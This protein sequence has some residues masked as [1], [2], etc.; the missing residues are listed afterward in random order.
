MK[1]VITSAAMLTAVV[2]APAL[3]Q[4][5]QAAAEPAHGQHDEMR[6]EPVTRAQM[7]QKVQSHFA[8]VDADNDGV[9]TKAEMQAM[10]GARHERM[11]KHAGMRREHTFERLDTNDDGSISRSEFDAAHAGMAG[12]NGKAG[13]KRMRMHG[14]IFEMADANNDGRVTLQEATAAAAEHFDRADA[15][16]D[17]VLTA[18]EMRAAHKAHMGKPAG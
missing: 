11:E 18:D 6:M 1:L 8:R 4:T 9:V 10:R 3:A 13:H 7:L 15:N 14:Q 2:M 16:R 17:G 5:V 12:H